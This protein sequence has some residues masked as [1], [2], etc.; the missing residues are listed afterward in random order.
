MAPGAKAFNGKTF[1]FAEEDDMELMR[2]CIDVKPFD[3]TGLNLM[4]LVFLMY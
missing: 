1:R 3:N 4:Y 2:E